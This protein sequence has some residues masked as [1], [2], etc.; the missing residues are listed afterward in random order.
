MPVSAGGVGNVR[1]TA[2]E[3]GG[4]AVANIGRESID[5]NQLFF[6]PQ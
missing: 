3:G 2:G 6:F 5:G 4:G 1:G